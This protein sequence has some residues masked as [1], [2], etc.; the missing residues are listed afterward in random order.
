MTDLAVAGSGVYVATL[1]VSLTYTNLN[2]QSATKG[3]GSPAGEVEALSLATGKVEWDT[4]VPALP[5]GGATMSNDLV[6]WV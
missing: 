5:L 6:F 1:D 3:A 4:K 2:L